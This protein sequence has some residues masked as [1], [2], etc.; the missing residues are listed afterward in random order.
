MNN[1]K[2]LSLRMILE[3]LFPHCKVSQI[4]GHNSGLLIIIAHGFG[5]VVSWLQVRW[6]MWVVLSIPPPTIRPREQA[7]LARLEVLW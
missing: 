6:S 1:R 4:L 5:G 7:D 2:L 3:L